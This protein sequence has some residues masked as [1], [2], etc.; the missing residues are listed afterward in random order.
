LERLEADSRI[1]MK[2]VIKEVKGVMREQRTLIA[3][4]VDDLFILIHIKT[5][6]LRS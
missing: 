6:E 5:N 2:T 1:I 3:L 4:N